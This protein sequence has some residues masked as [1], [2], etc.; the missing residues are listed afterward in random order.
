[1]HVDGAYSTIRSQNPQLK[2]YA[3]APVL[4]HQRPSRTD[5]READ[6]LIA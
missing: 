2:T 1:M 4:G 5:I 6:G 3:I